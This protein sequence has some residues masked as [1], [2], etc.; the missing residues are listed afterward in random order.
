MK[1]LF[2]KRRLDYPRRSGHDV[3]TFELMRGL[4]RLGHEISLATLDPLPGDAVQGL[5]L[6]RVA[7]LTEAAPAG[8]PTLHLTALQEKFRR[9]WGIP[10][11][12]ILDTG[13][14]ATELRVDATVVS[15]LDVLPLLGAVKT[16][17]R[18]WYAGDE[19]VRHHLSLVRITDRSTWPQ[20]KTAAI[21]GVYERTYASLV[22]RA[23][24]VT[25]G[26]AV[27]MRRYAGVKHVDVLPNGIDTAHFA[28]LDPP[29]P[30]Q[31]DST[32]F[33]G[34]LDFE[35]N[36]DAVTWFATQVWPGIRRRRPAATFTIYGFEPS[37]AVG[38]WH[39]RDGITVV[40]DLPD[41]RRHVQRH[42]VVVLPF[43]SGGGIKNKLLEAA[44][45]ARP[46]VAS[47]VAAE[48]LTG[49]APLQV[50]ASAAAWVDAV[51]GLMAD[52]HGRERMGHAARAWVATAHSWDSAARAAAGGLDAHP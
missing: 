15:G 21:K 46:I 36:I 32:C 51:T 4:Q 44:A 29:V 16:G 26:E 18:I 9:Y 20:I 25:P 41:L 8:G 7:N 35:P 3:H 6:T 38:R 23:W 37:P 42:Q 47:R 30:E 40:A 12:P 45:M 22:D 10:V 19:W 5:T 43:V 13:R 27:A 49:E 11:G 34:R 28:P 1:W 52:P 50:P 17:R 39:G 14:L 24:V 48:G 33:W 31:P 2:V